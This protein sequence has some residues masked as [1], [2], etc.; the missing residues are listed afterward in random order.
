MQ[1]ASSEKKKEKQKY[2]SEPFFSLFSF[3]QLTNAHYLTIKKKGKQVGTLDL[4]TG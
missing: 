4:A 3:K 1:N 2:F